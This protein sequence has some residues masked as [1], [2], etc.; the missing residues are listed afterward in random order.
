MAAV[1]LLL[2]AL[3]A[4]RWSSIAAVLGVDASFR[5]FGRAVW[6]AQC[7][8]ELGP[9]L[10]VGEVAR[11]RSMRGRAEN[12]P[13]VLSQAVDR[14]SGHAALLLIVL[15]LTPFYVDAF[16]DF[17]LGGIGLAIFLTLAGVSLAVRISRRFWPLAGLDRAGVMSVCDPRVSPQH[18]LIS[19][20]IQVL[21]A[22]NLALAAFGLGVSPD[23]A[24]RIL[25]LSPL[26]LLGVGVL[27]G[28]VSDWGK[29]EAAAVLLLAPAGLSA[30][31]SLAASVV[32]GL[33]HTIMTLPGLA[34]IVPGETKP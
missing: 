2:T 23:A 32:F 15:A 20:L 3:F 24:G 18:Y 33:I 9:A 12:G 5:D 11:F 1:F 8:S 25:L 30:E 22:A 27:P 28:L 4:L 14:L 31:E 29:R 6:I 7:V 10:V 17:P 26:V 13:L 21:L 34:F 19:F 16:G